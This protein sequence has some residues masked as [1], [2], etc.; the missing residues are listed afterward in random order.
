MLLYD[1]DH[2]TSSL[3]VLPPLKEPLD[4]NSHNWKVIED[5][6]LMVC[7]EIYLATVLFL[8]YLRMFSEQLWVGQTSHCSTSM[9]S[10]PG[11]STNSLVLLFLCRF[12]TALFSSTR[13]YSQRRGIHNPCC[14]GKFQQ[15]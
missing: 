9:H 3:A 1:K 13:V 8:I 14:E 15:I 4:L 6:F 2:P 10:S 5:D 11:E 12:L 7:G